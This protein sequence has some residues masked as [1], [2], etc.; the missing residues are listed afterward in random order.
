MLQGQADARSRRWMMRA[1]LWHCAGDD[2]Q[3]RP[4]RVVSCG[5]VAVTRDGSVGVRRRGPA[6]GYAGLATCGS[7]W[8]CPVCNSKIQARRRLEVHSAAA[9]VYG[10][11]GSGAFGAYTLRHRVGDDGDALWRALS[12]CWEAVARDKS[13]RT[14][15]RDLGLLGIIR[16]A[17]VTHGRHGWHPHLHP[18]MLF[19]GKVTDAD[20]SRLH[21]LQIGAW[22]RAAERLGLTAVSAS[23]QELHRLTGRGADRDI[24][25]YFTKATYELTSTQTKSDTRAKNSVTPWEILDAMAAGDDYAADLWHQWER[26][27]HGKRALTWSRGLRDLV[28]LGAVERSD[29]DVAA[30]EVGTG[31]DTVFV[32]DDWSPFRAKPTLGPLVL[33]ALETGGDVAAR[34]VLDQHAVTYRR[35][36]F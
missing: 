34:R 31:E 33:R 1:V 14:A 8:L 36:A 11:G 23:A 2:S 15:R 21:A 7:V 22:T 20:V 30:E 4:L 19:A 18:L 29:E 13:V 25:D 35:P 5:R 6:V 17:E 3:G 10:N 16:A 24:A 32:I 28:G 27:S 12:A 26:I 9:W